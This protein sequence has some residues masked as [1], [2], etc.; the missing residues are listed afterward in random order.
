MISARHWKDRRVVWHA[1]VFWVW[2]AG[3]VFSFAASDLFHGPN[4]PEEL[5]LRS[6]SHAATASHW[7]APHALQ[8][9][10]ECATCLLQRVALGVLATVALLFLP[11][12]VALIKARLRPFYLRARSLAPIARGPPAPVIR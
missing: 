1:L 5:A 9:D 3:F 11:S 12:G 2:L 10:F 7:T 8:A 4:C 6:A